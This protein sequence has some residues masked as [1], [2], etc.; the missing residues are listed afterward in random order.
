MA[1][2]QSVQCFGKKKTGVS[3]PPAT[4]YGEVQA[5]ETD[6]KMKFGYKNGNFRRMPGSNRD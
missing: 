3:N 6:V 1:P 2:V 4:T 5:L